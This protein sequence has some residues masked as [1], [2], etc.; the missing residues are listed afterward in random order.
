MSKLIKYVVAVVLKPEP[1]SDAVLIVR[2]PED[3]PDLKG[4]W[5]LPAVTMTHHELPESAAR[6]ICREKLN[7]E[8]E[9]ERFL[10][11]MFQK[12]NS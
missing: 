6:R 4:A 5:G 8:A 1:G 9:P 3:D 11:L 12:R 7:C 10:G 2:R